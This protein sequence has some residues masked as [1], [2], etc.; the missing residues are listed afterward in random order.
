MKPG[1]TWSNTELVHLLRVA[2][3]PRSLALCCKALHAAFQDSSTWRKV[4]LCLWPELTFGDALNL[5]TD[6]RQHMRYL[7]GAIVP[8]SLKEVKCGR[9]AS[10]ASSGA[11]SP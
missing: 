6:W 4:A 11:L 3:D 2:E 1:S 8:M 7:S 10:M 5:I 9:C